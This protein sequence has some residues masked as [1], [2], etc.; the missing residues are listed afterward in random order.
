MDDI[1]KGAKEVGF[2]EYWLRPM[3]CNFWTGY[4]YRQITTTEWNEHKYVPGAPL[5]KR[6]WLKKVKL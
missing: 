3:F 5:R 2:W 1:L 6:R 4:V